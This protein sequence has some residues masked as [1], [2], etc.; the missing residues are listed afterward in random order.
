MDTQQ[1]K[2]FKILLL[3]DSCKDVYHY[4]TCDRISPEAPVPVLKQIKT[5]I[6]PGMSANVC[7]NLLAFDMEVSH[8][9]NEAKIEKHRYID[10]RYNQHLLRQ[11]IGEDKKLTPIKL[12][13]INENVPYD[14]IVISDYNKG[15]L[16]EPECAHICKI[17]D[18]TPI[19]VDTKKNNLTCFNNCV[20]KINEKEFKEIQHLP[21]DSEFIVTL[22][23]RGALYN[24]ERFFDSD[25]AEV[26][27]VTGAG[28]VFLSALV[29]G[30]LSTNSMHKAIE[31][32]NKCAKVSVSKM[33]TYTLTQK[34]INEICV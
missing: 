28:D 18:K 15:F 21:I 13:L 7:N 8:L 9:T 16:E 17:Y 11:D 33:G 26:Y 27:D 3:G 12:S 31:L 34:D 2:K 4:G 32:A 20:I 23:A 24:N 1:H 29:Y 22:G 25:P 14:A 19:F 5:I 30:F 10:E 6:K